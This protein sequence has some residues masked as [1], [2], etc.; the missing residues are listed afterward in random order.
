[1]RQ[2]QRLQ[3]Q[4]LHSASSVAR[5][6][7]QPDPPIPLK[8]AEKSRPTQN[9]AG[10]SML[11]G[12][13]P[14]VQQ[15][16]AILYAPQSAAAALAAAAEAKSLAAAAAEAAAVEKSP[17]AY[18]INVSAASIHTI[19]TWLQLHPSARLC[20]HSET[21]IECQQM[22]HSTTLD[23][24]VDDVSA[25]YPPAEAADAAE[26][27]LALPKEEEA[28]AEEA[29]A[30]NRRRPAPTGNHMTILP[31][32]TDNESG[33][34]DSTLRHLMACALFQAV[35]PPLLWEL[36]LGKKR[37]ASM[38]KVQITYGSTAPA[39]AADEA[40]PLPA[41]EPAAAPPAPAT[42]LAAAADPPGAQKPEVAADA[43]AAAASPAA[44]A[45]EAAPAGNTCEG[46]HGTGRWMGS[47]QKFLNGY[48]LAFGMPICERKSAGDWG[49]VQV[50]EHIPT[51]RNML[52]MPFSSIADLSEYVRQGRTWVACSSCR[53]RCSACSPGGRGGA[54][55]GGRRRSCMHS[56]PCTSHWAHGSPQRL[57]LLLLLSLQF[58]LC[59]IV[60]WHC[61]TSS[62]IIRTS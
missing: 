13:T 12:T 20:H 36:L 2:Q 6:W 49:N 10:S 21:S 19:S 48:R 42:A 14:G 32:S 34:V 37:I 55:G 44:A 7:V 17:A 4:P 27:A 43:A 39:A 61:K 18:V 22:H 30:W 52:T 31:G 24:N 35:L 11:V 25:E 45:E 47:L 33:P 8:K 54:G 15:L 60:T 57:L 53:R 59:C 51:C 1:M 62:C 40:A 5:P 28:A 23:V 58:Q 9:D 46:M 26:A 3:L 56:A 16:Q 29:A 38:C 41:A 50:I